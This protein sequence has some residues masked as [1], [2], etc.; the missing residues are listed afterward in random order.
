MLLIPSLMLAAV[1]LALRLGGYGFSTG[2]FKTA[3][4][5]NEQFVI[6]N[7]KFS[8]RF[9]PPELMR[10]PG[11]IRMKPSKSPGTYR[12]FILGESAA[13]GDPEPGFAAARYLQVLL[14]ER[15]PETKFEIVNVAFTAINSHVILPIARDCASRDGDLWIIYM[16]N[17]EMVGPFGAATVFGPKA[18]PLTLVRLSLAAQQTRLGQLLAALLDR[19]KPK[20]GR[21]SWGGMQMFL[22]NQVPPNSAPRKTVYR[23]FEKNLEDI[24]EA[25]LDSGARIL[26]NTV[27]VNLKDCPPFGSASPTNLPANDRAKL[28]Q[29]LGQIAILGSEKNSST[30]SPL[31]ASAA[32]IHRESADLQYRW[33]Q[34]LLGHD[35][36]A[37][38]R[39]QA[40]CDL[41]T[42]PFRTDSQ[43]N[44]AIRKVAAQAAHPSLALFES[45]RWLATNSP[46]GIAGQEM[47]YE[48]VH[49]NFEG[50][51]LLGRGWAEQVSKLLP[52]SL[53]KNAAADW[54]TAETCDRRLGLTAWNRVIVLEGM[55]RRM[56]QAPLSEQSNNQNRMAALQKQVEELRA[57][58][59]PASALEAREMYLEAIRRAPDDYAVRENFASFLVAT[60]D[61]QGAAAQWQQ[62]HEMIP[63]DYLA[64]FRWGE[65][66]AR[67]GKFSDA[68]T[69]LERAAQMR[70]FLSD[71]PHEL[72][73]L[74]IAQGKFDLAL[75]AFNRAYRLQPN[76]AE[77]LY[78]IGRSL[79]LLKR[80]NEGI[81]WL[82]MAIR[83]DPNHWQTHDALG[84]QLGLA[85]K[86]D[87]AK[88]E[89]MHVTRLQPNYA[90]GHLNLGVALLKEGKA[91]EAAL[92]LQRAVQL[93]PTNAIAHD[94]LR[95]AETA[96]GKAQ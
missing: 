46:N 25:G 43:V 87:E 6:E 85:G 21:A 67:L 26:L 70:P 64:T 60:G 36:A 35:P 95:Q 27:A 92:A 90:R 41:D 62:V 10:T 51:Y 30:A 40:A 9:F 33:G 31:L 8:L 37:A 94:Y 52:E 24:V 72:G 88:A 84:G 39:F 65:L 82:R 57:T 61:L 14:R 50:N 71:P 48:H 29:V 5:G 11:P 80:V 13:M 56:S 79:I 18:P 86:V 75:E 22:S 34:S 54:P 20:G 68:R 4:I 28:E 59:N 96:A 3:Q 2:L 17:N 74:Y 81:E 32:A 83:Q 58:M 47:F 44:R 78:Q 42:L 7:E 12:I 53:K 73:K 49:F 91:A 15:Y 45:D 63:Q 1:E 16:G 93:D 69:I 76:N 23:N 55:L 89:F 66:L 77:Y 19:L 38:E